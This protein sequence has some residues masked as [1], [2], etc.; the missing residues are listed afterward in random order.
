MVKRLVF[1]YHL[2][3]C[4]QFIHRYYGNTNEHNILVYTTHAKA[5][6]YT[7]V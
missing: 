5:E 6:D 2:M 4:L 1:L 3:I 7:P